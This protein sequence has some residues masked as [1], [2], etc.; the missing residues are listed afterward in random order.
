M[1]ND[2]F[3]PKLSFALFSFSDEKIWSIGMRHFREDDKSPAS[4]L[5]MIAKNTATKSEIQMADCTKEI[6]ETFCWF[7]L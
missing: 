1:S 3:M 4:S 6:A 7:D 2:I 5:V